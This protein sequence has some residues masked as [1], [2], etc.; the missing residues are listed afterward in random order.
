MPPVLLKRL[1]WITLALALTALAA[2]TLIDAG[3]KT[4]VAPHGIVSFELCAYGKRC[5]AML[6][7]WS[8]HARDLA[9]L[10]LGLDYLFMLLYPG[11]ICLALLLAQARTAGRARAWTHALAGGIWLTA[12][13]DATENFCL[14]QMTL[15]S[16]IG[17]APGLTAQTWAWPASLAAT[18]KFAVLGIALAWLAA[19]YA[20]YPAP[21]HAAES[22]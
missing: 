21:P 3:L 11:A 9:L 17:S 10:S 2:L 20:R 12:L 14:I 19:V 1:F 13:A 16:P 22:S 18:V 8:P 7:A 4:P 5:A 15:A 6:Q